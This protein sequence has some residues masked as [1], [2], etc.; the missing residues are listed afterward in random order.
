MSIEQGVAFAQ[1]LKD[2]LLQNQEDRKDRTAD[3]VDTLKGMGEDVGEIVEEFQVESDDYAK[4]MVIMNDKLN[5]DIQALYK[6]VYPEE[7]PNGDA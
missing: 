1:G 5:K 7:E 3:Y 2:I 6:K 4:D